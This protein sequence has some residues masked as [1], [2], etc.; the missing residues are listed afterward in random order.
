M[1]LIPIEGQPVNILQQFEGAFT[2]PPSDEFCVLYKKDEDRIYL[3]M[4]QTPCDD[5]IICNPYFAASGES[6]IVLN[7]TFDDDSNWAQVQGVWSIADNKACITNQTGTLSQNLPDLIAGSNYTVTFTVLDLVDGGIYVS[8]GGTNTTP[9]YSNG[10]Y[11]YTVNA[12]SLNTLLRF[13]TDSNKATLCISDISVV[14]QGSDCW[15]SDGSFA[16]SGG[17]ASGIVGES[18]TIS[19][20]ITGGLDPSKYYLIEF[21]VSGASDGLLEV[22]LG[23][24]TVATVS[25]NGSYSFYTFTPA[26]DDL[27]TFY[28]DE[29]FNGRV[30]N[31]RFYLMLSSSEINALVKIVNA[32]DLTIVSG[33]DV[34]LGANGATSPYGGSNNPYGEYINISIHTAELA[35]GCYRIKAFDPCGENT[36]PEIISDNT[37]TGS[38]WDDTGGNNNTVLDGKITYTENG[39]AYF[40]LTNNSIPVIPSTCSYEISVT[41]GNVD[42]DLLPSQLYVLAGGDNFFDVVANTTVTVIVP[43]VSD[44]LIM[45]QLFPPSP[46]VNGSVLEVLNISSKPYGLCGTNVSYSP[47]ISNCLKVSSNIGTAKLLEGRS[48]VEESLGF[49]FNPEFWLTCRHYVSFTNPHRPVKGENYLYSNGS[50]QKHYAQV[51][52]QWDLVVDF[53]DESMHDAIATMLACRQ[54][55]IGEAA[56]NKTQYITEDKSYS[57][58]WAF[59]GAAPLSQATIEIG[60]VEGGKF[61]IN[62]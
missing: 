16:L 55:Y 58:D 11:T 36:N 27:L 56:D 17:L 5:S 52:K 46:G 24:T 54:F 3:Q 4:K 15:E 2:C 8:L 43:F 19:Q 23:G 20:E 33:M 13:I 9:V 39:D 6:S 38:G 47:Y 48:D 14:L 42:A 12:G 34:V 40:E 22:G 62:R 57:P 53:C 44:S 7:G 30:T 50:R 59:K 1:A 51:D 10:I 49:Y 28:K 31:V 41:F 61:N 29:A 25:E 45:V 60:R 37:F 18:G 21:E 32:D 26:T 35:E